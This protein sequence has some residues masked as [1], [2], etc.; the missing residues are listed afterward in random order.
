MKRNIRSL[1]VEIL[2][3]EKRFSVKSIADK[4]EI[5]L[6]IAFQLC[7][8]IEREYPDVKKYSIIQCS[9]C[10]NNIQGDYSAN[11]A[12]IIDIECDQCRTDISI[13]ED[14]IKVYYLNKNVKK[15]LLKPT[16]KNFSFFM[17]TDFRKSCEIV[18]HY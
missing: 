12:G 11:L 13:K 10:G 8:E 14:N 7:K 4:Y 5:D 15:K 3:S 2:K 9:E 6:S 18:V 17:S 16:I 1:L